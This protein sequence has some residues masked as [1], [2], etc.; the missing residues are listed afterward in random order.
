MDSYK[1]AQEKEKKTLT[2]KLESTKKK[3]GEAQ[4]EA[5][6]QRLELGR[7]QALSK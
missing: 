6:K 4:D 5:M 3:L 1:Q 2:D 7:E